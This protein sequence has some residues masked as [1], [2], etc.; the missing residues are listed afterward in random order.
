MATNG[1]QKLL[2]DNDP[3]SMAILI[4]QALGDNPSCELALSSVAT[5]SICSGE[6]SLRGAQTTF[7]T[8]FGPPDTGRRGQGAAASLAFLGVT[9]S[10]P[11]PITSHGKLFLFTNGY[12]Q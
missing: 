6:N 12:L 1:S 8:T 10:R 4:G 11:L 9:A 7:R 3:S 2:P 5:H